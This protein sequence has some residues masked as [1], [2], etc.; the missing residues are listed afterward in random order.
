MYLITTL[1]F[2]AFLNIHIPAS[3][4]CTT[5]YALEVNDIQHWKDAV[6]ALFAGT[7]DM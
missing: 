3:W 1:P 7:L 4:A 2:L 6:V 5:V